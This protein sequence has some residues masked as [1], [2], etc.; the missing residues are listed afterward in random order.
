MLIVL[1]LFQ[2]NLKKLKL[3]KKNLKEKLSNV[4]KLNL[5]R[6]L[7]NMLNFYKLNLKNFMSW[8]IKQL[9][10]YMVRL[11]RML[12]LLLNFLLGIIKLQKINKL[13]N[14]L[15]NKDQS[16]KYQNLLL[17]YKLLIMLW[18]RCYSV[19]RILKHLTLI[20]LIKNFYK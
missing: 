14:F 9:M 5:W 6:V 19:Q 2:I 13:K 4:N 11:T 20:N 3:N 1:K 7:K 18:I 10:K 8:F 15:L 17:Q 16:N 12:I